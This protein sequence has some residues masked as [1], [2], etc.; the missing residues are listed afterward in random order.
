M[1]ADRERAPLFMVLDPEDIIIRVVS[2]ETEFDT[3]KVAH[4]VVR[5]MRELSFGFSQEDCTRLAR[6]RTWSIIPRYK[7]V[8]L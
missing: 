3:V 5:H 7:S 6:E 4:F 8:R 2:D 1:T